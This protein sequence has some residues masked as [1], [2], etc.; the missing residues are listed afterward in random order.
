MIS[1]RSVVSCY[2]L[3]TLLLPG[4]LVALL[5]GVPD[6]RVQI[7]ELDV[8]EREG[9][10]YELK[11]RS[12]AAAEL[13]PQDPTVL[14][15][16]ARVSDAF[17]DH[18]AEAYERWTDALMRSGAPQ[19]TITQALERGV[20]VALRDGD[21]ERAR[22]MAS[23]LDFASRFSGLS[24]VEQDTSSTSNLTVAGGTA[25]LAQAVQ[26]DPSIPASRFMAEY[27][28]AVLRRNNLETTPRK[29]FEDR[30]KRYFDV[31]RALSSYARQD[32]GQTEIILDGVNPLE[33]DRTEKILAV[34]GWRLRRLPGG[35]V[36]LELASGAEN[37]E[38]Q[39]V[40][41]AIG[42]DEA[43][44]KLTLE[45]KRPFVLHLRNDR[46]PILLDP[47]F[48]EKLTAK[49]DTPSRGLLEDLISNPRVAGLYVALSNMND[50]TQRAVLDV[51][52]TEELLDRTKQLSLY[53]A[54]ISIENGRLVLPG[55]VEATDA[56]T[57]LVE[58]DPS[59]IGQFLKNLTKKDGGKLLAYYHALAVL[60]LQNQ[61]FFARS[62]SR[63]TRFYAVFPYSDERVVGRGLFMRK[64][65]PFTRLA[66][67]I[68]LDAAGNVRFPGSD[69]VWMVAT[70]G[71][72][73]V[74]DA[75]VLLQRVGRIRTPDAEDEILLGML[76]RE[77]E[78]DMHRRFRFVQNF[79]AV[80]R[81]DAH[82]RQP[83]DET[84]AL[85]LAQNYA[86]YESIFPYF[87]E[88]TEL[89]GQQTSSFFQAA[90]RLET[91]SGVE[92]NTVLGEFHSLLKLVSLLH[93]SRVISAAQAAELFAMVCNNFAGV[94][95]PG[96]SA[97]V[98]FDSVERILLEIQNVPG[99]DADA[100]LLG[101]FAGQDLAK[102]FTSQGSSRSV[103]LAGA[104]RRRMREVLRLQ[105][106]VPL[107]VLLQT[108]RAARKLTQGIDE[109]S[110]KE[111]E[112]NL[113][114][115]VEIV[116]TERDQL[117]RDFADS[118]LTGRPSELASLVEK[119][120]KLLAAKKPSQQNS[121]KLANDFI[122]HLGPFLQ[123]TLSGWIYAYY[124]SPTD[125][126]VVSNRYFV[127]SHMFSEPNLKNY[128]PKTQLQQ[129]PIGSRIVGGFA[130]IGSVTGD[131]AATALDV[132]ES[133]GRYHAAVL[134]LSAVRSVPWNALAPRSIHLA[135]LRI[136]LGREF[137]VQAAFSEPLRNILQNAT[138][139][140]IGPARRHDLLQA[141]NAR[142]VSYAMSLLTASDLFFL[143]DSF[144]ETS[145]DKGNSAGLLLAYRNEL[146]LV[147][148]QQTDYFGGIHPETA[149][150]THPHLMNS[151]P[152]E[153]YAD[154]LF[155]TALAE[156]MSD[157]LLEVVESA[158]RTTLPVEAVGM[159][160]ESA[161]REFFRKTRNTPREDWLSA[162]QAMSTIDLSTFVD[163]LERR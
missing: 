118:V 34:L 128:W 92:L 141:I 32:T 38:R 151:P 7:T 108:Y 143:A 58:A 59:Q 2:L 155:P 95:A 116:P 132:S 127:R 156:R 83:M 80:V 144:I 90:R 45:A 159:L 77:Y 20:V 163:V 69:R 97:A 23:R 19:P 103:N 133:L 148:L 79:L 60:P 57:K 129:T 102:Q 160:A 47:P 71:T 123:T 41:S 147:P 110:L 107:E 44:M 29:S 10:I 113:V 26:I 125:L 76:E 87:A 122:A 119:F 67:E 130:E 139:G 52:P 25:A 82:R 138:T 142:D 37:G 101:A 42:I 53:G 27:A 117:P 65:D 161:V 16:A 31:M 121:A 120:Q 64:E 89:T 111:I 13:Q 43:D 86:K 140:A 5:Q 78:N 72:K 99:D 104:N 106:I 150:C 1:V 55:G 100:R 73:N 62:A 9:D 74:D 81:V 63:L 94:K 35:N 162:A 50:Q 70:V 158:D 105:V 75:Q 68:P 18:A 56:W 39:Q 137:I 91:F 3:F 93:E 149:G 54:S 146:R 36:L 24:T 98:S 40:G 22:R 12:R 15:Y 136:R 51:V 17:G 21:R 48:W 126:S 134:H 8:L 153:D 131:I 66:R 30:L 145:A 28:R 85:L 124:L 157:I 11:E 154:Q 46:V 114:N 4:S 61:Q 135:A 96:E 49:R 84:M 33:I 152:Y 115:I 112:S 14:G 109:Q 6:S 88:L